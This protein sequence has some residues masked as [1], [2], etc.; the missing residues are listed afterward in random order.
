MDKDEVSESANQ[1]E[2]NEN[3]DDEQDN[4]NEE[5]YEGEAPVMEVTEK[6]QQ[7]QNLVYNL[8]INS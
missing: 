3:N 2:E 7:V 4:D 6:W 1:E 5:D 8:L